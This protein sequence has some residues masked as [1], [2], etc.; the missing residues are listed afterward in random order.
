M[1]EEIDLQ[2]EEK[3][4]KADAKS[5]VDMF[6]IKGYFSESI[7]R[8]DM[9]AVEELVQFLLVSKFKMYVKTHELTER[10]KK[11]EKK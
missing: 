6:F 7:T 8:D 11:Q 10:L 4:F 9:V 5:L 2:F 1:A 3:K